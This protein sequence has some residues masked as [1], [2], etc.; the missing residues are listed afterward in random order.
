MSKLRILNTINRSIDALT[1][2]IAEYSE[3]GTPEECR[4][5]VE[6]Q[7]PKK[8]SEQSCAEKTLFKCGNCGYIMKIKYSDGQVCGHIPNYCEQCGQKMEKK[9]GEKSDG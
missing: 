6:K 3:I 8:P 4:A 5:A 9:Y 1:K 7:K 2:V